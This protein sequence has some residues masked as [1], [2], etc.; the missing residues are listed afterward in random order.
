MIEW[1]PG[2]YKSLGS[3]PQSH[4]RDRRRGEEG[5]E[6]RGER[7]KKKEQEKKREKR[8]EWGREGGG[9]REGGNQSR[10]VPYWIIFPNSVTSSV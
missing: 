6:R 1:I 9:K 8:E 2:R 4:K 10:H 7:K 3:I 5:R